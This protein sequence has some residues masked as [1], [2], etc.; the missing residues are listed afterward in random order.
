[1]INSNRCSNK[2]WQWCMVQEWTLSIIKCNRCNSNHLVWCSN[3]N[4]NPICITTNKTN[5][6]KVP[7][8]SN[9]ISRVETNKL[10]KVLLELTI[11]INRM[12]CYHNKHSHGLLY[13]KLIKH[14]ELINQ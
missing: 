8:D 13:H 4:N 5:G 11:N 3:N 9:M 2:T 10:I 6:I 7:V 14:M 12:P 1:M